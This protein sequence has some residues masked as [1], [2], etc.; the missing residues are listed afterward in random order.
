MWFLI[1]FQSQ[2]SFYNPLPTLYGAKVQI[3]RGALT[4]S[5]LLLTQSSVN[6]LIWLLPA[7]VPPTRP[8]LYEPLL[9]RR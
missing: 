7:K 2:N 4:Q 5:R 9:P 8:P 1:K 3:L 6:A